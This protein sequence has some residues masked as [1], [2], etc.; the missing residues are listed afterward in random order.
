MVFCVT[1]ILLL[2]FY[3]CFHNFYYL[4]PKHDNM[5]IP[6][7]LPSVGMSDKFWDCIFLLLSGWT[8]LIL[9]LDQDVSKFVLLSLFPSCTLIFLIIPAI[10][11]LLILRL[12]FV[13]DTIKLCIR[14]WIIICVFMETMFN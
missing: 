11:L 14:G 12:L 9:N 1:D 3:S 8:E 2:D 7:A 13:F 4:I 5:E 6:Q 10:E